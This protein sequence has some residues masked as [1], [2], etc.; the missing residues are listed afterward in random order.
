MQKRKTD[1]VRCRVVSDWHDPNGEVARGLRTFV[2]LVEP[3]AII[4]LA[5]KGLAQRRE[6]AKSYIAEGM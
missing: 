5:S 1:V 2:G 3:R 6:G 4:R